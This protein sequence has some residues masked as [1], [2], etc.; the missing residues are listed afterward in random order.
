MALLQLVGPQACAAGDGAAAGA[1][2]LRGAGALAVPV[3][4]GGVEDAPAEAAC[5]VGGGPGGHAQWPVSA[6]TGAASAPAAA[7]SDSV[8]FGDSAADDPWRCAPLL[9][10]GGA[11]AGCFCAAPAACR[12]VLLH[13]TYYAAREQRMTCSAWA[14][15]RLYAGPGTSTTAATPTALR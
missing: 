14:P 13:E 11:K 8:L 5:R 15:V 6:S 3:A 10:C 12:I 1:C 4:R 2:H 9:A 7:A